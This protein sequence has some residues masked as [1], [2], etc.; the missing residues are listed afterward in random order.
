MTC[1]LFRS[2]PLGGL[3]LIAAIAATAVCH[4]A[5]ATSF[6]DV[7]SFWAQTTVGDIPAGV[8][9]TCDGDAYPIWYGSAGCSGDMSVG[10]NFTSNVTETNSS[11]G[12]LL[13]TNIGGTPLSGDL[14]FDA[15]FSAFNPGGPE[16]GLGIDNAGK[17]ASYSSI[18]TGLGYVLDEHACSLPASYL[19]YDYAG[20]YNFSTLTCGV[21]A[22]DS[23]DVL[24]D[25]DLGSLAPGDTEEFTY[26]MSISD[27]FHLALEPSGLALLGSAMFALGVLR[28]RS[29]D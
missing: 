8:A 26:S 27:S 16:V 18:L 5:N 21:V 15:G 12:S 17:S 25:V 22:P 13:L 3:S 19:G 1:I 23:S 6:I 2:M 14:L 11:S 29:A 7:S 9:I 4:S 10:H 20:G 28:R 24:L